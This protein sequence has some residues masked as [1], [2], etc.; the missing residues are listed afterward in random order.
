MLGQEKNLVLVPQFTSALGLSATHAGWLEGDL[1]Y[2][3]R[4][5]LPGCTGAE[6]GLLCEG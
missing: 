5:T 1:C 2:A 3:C 6:A 4:H